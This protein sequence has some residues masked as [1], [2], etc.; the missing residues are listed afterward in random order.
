[1]GEITVSL[2]CE[3]YPRKMLCHMQDTW[4]CQIKW[5]Q[6]GIYYI[7]DRLPLQLIVTSQLGEKEHKWLKS[8]TNHITVK[9]L[10]LILADYR[11]EH[12]EL[13]PKE[14]R[15]QIIEKILRVLSEQSW[16]RE[17]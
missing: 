16:R 7:H 8:L 17:N 14:Y 3:H 10:E 12:K 1:M 9:E 4:G 15:N 13:S 2:V 11:V 5:Y 6:P